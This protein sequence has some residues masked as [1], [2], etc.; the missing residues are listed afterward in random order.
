[1]RCERLYEDAIVRRGALAGCKTFQT[2]REQ[3]Y[4]AKY[5]FWKSERIAMIHTLVNIS[6][7]C[8][9]RDLGVG[10]NSS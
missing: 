9:D 3:F 7:H 10:A 5:L 6:R 2:F 8:S 4:V 1:M